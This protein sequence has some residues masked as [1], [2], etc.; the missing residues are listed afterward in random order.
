MCGVGG[1]SSWAAPLAQ[2]AVPP[3]S[4]A[5]AITG[6]ASGV[7]IVADRVQAAQW[8]SVAVDISALNP[9]LGTAQEQWHTPFHA[10]P[11]SRY[12]DIIRSLEEPCQGQEL[13]AT[14]EEF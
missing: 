9:A 6:A 13:G 10:C 4:L 2:F 11:V 7:P 8:Q 3:R 14:P 5:S 12:A 1:E